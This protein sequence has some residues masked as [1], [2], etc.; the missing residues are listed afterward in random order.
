MMQSSH[1]TVRAGRRI[2]S[3]AFLA[4]VPAVVVALAALGMYLH[5]AVVPIGFVDAQSITGRLLVVIF[6]VSAASG[7]LLGAAALLRRETPRDS[8]TVAII[9]GMA[10]LVLDRVLRS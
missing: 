2:G 7:I 8:A 3:A 10:L 4:I 9:V 5:P 6:Y 1:D